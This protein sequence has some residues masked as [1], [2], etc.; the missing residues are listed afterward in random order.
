MPTGFGELY[1]GH[2][3]LPSP[4]AILINTRLTKNGKTTMAETEVDTGWHETII[5]AGVAQRI[6]IDVPAL[7]RASTAWGAGSERIEQFHVR[8]DRLEFL[9]NGKRAA[10]SIGPVFVRMTTHP[11]WT[12]TIML[13]ADVLSLIEFK[14]SYENR[15]TPPE[16][17]CRTPRNESGKPFRPK[18]A[19]FLV[20]TRFTH[21]G[22]T[23]E[24]EGEID[25]GAQVTVV[26]LNVAERLGFPRKAALLR[27]ISRGA[28]GKRVSAYRFPVDQLDIM[29]Q[30]GVVSCSV[31]NILVVTTGGFGPDSVRIG[32]DVLAELQMSVWLKDNLLYRCGV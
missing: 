7:K 9:L 29:N 12:D 1:P 4:D 3:K 22:L 18:W 2:R 8:I 16:L 5:G 26:G 27:T 32:R 11:A 31:R 19:S 6:G 23:V 21:G 10:C 30:E 15:R 24:T 28:A 17:Q 25:T 14:I 13:G 20:K